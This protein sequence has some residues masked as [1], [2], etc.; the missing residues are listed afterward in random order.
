MIRRGLDELAAFA[1]VAQAASFTRAAGQL[2]V[3]TSALSHTIRQLEARLGLRLLQRTS[4]R[5]AMTD[6]G[7]ELFA[8][9]SPALARIEETLDLLGEAAGQV[10]GP[11]RLTCT[12]HAYDG[13]IRP[14]LPAFCA[15]HPRARVEVM[16]D[17]R[18]RDII[19][20]GLDAGI[21]LGEKLQQDMVALRVGQ[22]LR[23]AVVA[24]PAYLAAHGAPATPHALTAHRCVIYRMVPNAAPLDWDF[25]EN[26]REFTIRVDGPL[27]TNDPDTM[28]QAAL[29]GLAIATVLEESVAPFV[30][31]GRLVRLLAE[32]TPP[33]PGYYL[34]YPSRRQMPPVL[35]AL[36]AE[37]RRAAR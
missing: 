2:G 7:A 9:L 3:S 8:T 26:G 35:A 28:L 31:E 21:R 14:V 27:A 23:M 37:L 15:A 29:D 22:D 4:R 30:A 25:A 6:A 16:V 10:A 12:R 5:V 33:F 11:V 13:I 18:L 24:S 32:W 1:A 19:A 34:Y 20:E 36:V 17:T